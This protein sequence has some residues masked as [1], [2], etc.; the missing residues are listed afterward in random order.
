[1]KYS[2]AASGRPRPRRSRRS[3]VRGL[4]HD[5]RL[6]RLEIGVERA[7]R[8]LPLLRREQEPRVAAPRVAAHRGRA[9][10]RGAP[11]RVEG[12]GAIAGVLARAAEREPRRGARSSVGYAATNC[13]SVRRPRSLRP[14]SICACASASARRLDE[15]ALR[16]TAGAAARSSRSATGH[17]RGPGG[18]RADALERVVGGLVRRELGSTS[19]R[20]VAS[21]PCQSCVGVDRD[22]HVEQRRDRRRL[23]SPSR[24][25]TA[26]RSK[27]FAAPFW[28]A[29]AASPYSSAARYHAGPASRASVSAVPRR[30]SG[31]AASATVPRPRVANSVNPPGA[32]RANCLHGV[33]ARPV[34]SSAAPSAAVRA[35]E[36]AAGTARA[37]SSRAGSRWRR[38]RLARSQH[39]DRAV[40]LRELDARVARRSATTMRSRSW[41][42][43]GRA[44]P[45]A[46]ASSDASRSA[47]TACGRSG[48]AVAKS[49]KWRRASSRWFCRSAVQPSARRA[50]GA[51]GCSRRL[52]QRA[53]ER[54]RRGRVVA[55]VV[56]GLAARA[57]AR[58]GA[59]S[60]GSARGQQ[61]RDV[62]QR[63]REFAQLE[64][65]AAERGA[66]RAGR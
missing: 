3:S 25:A 63:L 24:A 21:A 2:S 56:R 52:D 12:P 34:A 38:R 19:R 14:V 42:A 10:R 6:G 7:P 43:P 46:S 18:G 4:G 35:A 16:D 5:V 53:A 1:M 44:S 60:G 54:R 30:P 58:P 62:L 57:A 41:R 64:V 8:L 48:C 29:T 11:V 40:Q 47:S 36:R 37:R 15:G 45:A 28:N 33:R 49:R 22:E 32:P 66:R 65:R 61:R 39:Q 13:S 55:G 23:G 27:S 9:G 51:C 17:A 20:A 31:P 50:A 59:R 26:T